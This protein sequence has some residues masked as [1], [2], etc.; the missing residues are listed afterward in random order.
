[1]GRPRKEP[2]RITT[3]N[4][5]LALS[6]QID[7]LNLSNRSEWMAGVLRDY[8]K[9]REETA[10]AFADRAAVIAD[11]AALITQI[12]DRQLLAAALAR[13][14]FNKVRLRQDLVKAITKADDGVNFAGAAEYLAGIASRDAI[15]AEQD[16]DRATAVQIE[17]IARRIESGEL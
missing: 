13:I 11:P 3:F 1:M 6:E 10:E 9:R 4:L 17:D 14:P 7:G 2:R 16:P 8:F 5:P 12:P 15:L